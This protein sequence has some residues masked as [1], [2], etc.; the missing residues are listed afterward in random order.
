M[1]PDDI[2][3]GHFTCSGRHTGEATA[4]QLL[5]FLEERDVV[6][7]HVTVVGGD[8]TNSVTGYRGGLMAQ[9]ERIIN[10]PLTRVVCLNHQAE[11]PFRA[12]F[13]KLDGQTTGPSSFSGPIGH[14][15]T[16]PVH[17]LPVNFKPLTGNDL[18]ELPPAVVQGLSKDL[19]LLVECAACVVSGDG[20]LVQHRLHGQLNMARWHTAQ[21][22]LLRVY[23]SETEPS[24][25]LTELAVYVVNVYV[26]TVMAIRHHPDM[27]EAPKH[28]YSQLDRQR[29][30]LTGP[31]L[32]TVQQSLCRNSY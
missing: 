30:Y 21:S 29:R 6:I 9:L 8:G 1:H 18:P 26:P 28:L 14:K 15:L 27:V 32:V 24:P 20:S 22:R 11:L 25:E 16:G 4:E 7:G 19:R 17:E 3:I 23:M 12:L 2:F 10:R 5:S 13:K 31:A